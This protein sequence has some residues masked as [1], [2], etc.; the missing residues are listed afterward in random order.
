MPPDPTVIV[1]STPDEV[2]A[3][4]S[5]RRRVFVQEQSIPGELDD[6]GLDEGAVHVVAFEG[7]EPIA[8]G[9]LVIEKDGGVLARIAVLPGWRGRGL[10][11]EV[12]RKL[13]AAARER[14]VT[15]LSLHPHAHLE[16]FYAELGYETVPGRTTAGEHELITMRKR[17]EGKVRARR[18]A[19]PMTDPGLRPEQDQALGYAR[20]QGTEASLESIR[21]RMKRTF[22]ELE[23]VL[24]AVPVDRAFLRPGP[25][26][27]SVH[28]VVDHLVV[29]H[30]LAIGELGSLI[31]GVSPSSGPIPAGLVSDDPFARPWPEVLED[32]ERVHADLLEALTAADDAVPLDARAPV[33]M[34][35]KCATADGGVE[36]VEWVDSFDWKAYAI[37]LRAHT[38]EHLHQ[39]QRTLAE[40]SPD[41][42]PRKSPPG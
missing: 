20:R 35:V 2:A 19:P 42:S 16:R 34:V 15:E 33:V 5:I 10:G 23:E 11:A 25:G 22:R 9:R 1:A 3:A 31:A 24:T 26:R 38:L 41:A 27:W 6:D 4:R 39:V 12:V 21:S 28:E 8:T 40:V 29:S 37:L 13:E 32:L 36:P 18:E 7:T 14:G 30:R 17:L